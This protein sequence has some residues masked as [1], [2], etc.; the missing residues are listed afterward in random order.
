MCPCSYFKLRSNYTT[1]SSYTILDNTY[2]C[3]RNTTSSGADVYYR[4]IQLPVGKHSLSVLMGT[5]RFSSCT[6]FLLTKIRNWRF[7]YIKVI[8]ESNN[9]CTR[10]SWK[11][12]IN[13][14]ISNLKCWFF[15]II[16]ELSDNNINKTNFHLEYSE[17]WLFLLLLSAHVY[18]QDSEI[19]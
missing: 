17:F 16:A 7:Y 3:V 4:N 13:V 6:F 8:R 10:L 1:G 14:P 2:A 5:S 18:S 12:S 15:F 11:T 9:L 19:W